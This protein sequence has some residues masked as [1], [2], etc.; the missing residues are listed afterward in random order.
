VY[1]QTP[2][3]NDYTPL[4]IFPLFY[5]DP[6][7]AHVAGYSICE[8]GEKGNS[9]KKVIYERR[10]TYIPL[11]DT[12]TDN[13]YYQAP[14][15]R[16]EVE[17]PGKLGSSRKKSSSLPVSACGPTDRGAGVIVTYRDSE[18]NQRRRLIGLYTS[19]MRPLVGNADEIVRKSKWELVHQ[20]DW[21]ESAENGDVMMFT[22]LYSGTLTKS[23]LRNMMNPVIER[24]NSFSKLLISMSAAS[25][26]GNP[27]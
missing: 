22:P 11:I 15:L 12:H 14:I 21:K 27:Y 7:E 2:K 20:S 8:I 10:G 4:P 16:P 13:W 18:F 3:G 24:E 9:T 26:C 23:S 6:I 25:V 19:T 17:I 1:L 5:D